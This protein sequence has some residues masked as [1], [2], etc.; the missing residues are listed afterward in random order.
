MANAKPK[1]VPMRSRRSGLKKKKLIDANFAILKK[2]E[3][4]K[5]K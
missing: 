4:D 3:N 2:L 5:T 1:P